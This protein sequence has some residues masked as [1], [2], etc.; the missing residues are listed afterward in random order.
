MNIYEIN[1]TEYYLAN[2]AEEALKVFIRDTSD[3]IVL[4]EIYELSDLDLITMTMADVDE[5]ERIVNNQRTFKQQ[6]ILDLEKDSTTARHFAS[7]EHG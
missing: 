5:D 3:D 2:S 7:R 6:L 4:G 1:G